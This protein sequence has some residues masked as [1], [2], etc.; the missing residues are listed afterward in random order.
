MSPRRPRIRSSSSTPL[1]RPSRRKSEIGKV[2]RV[3]P[4]STLR[5]SRSRLR[6]P[7]SRAVSARARTASDGRLTGRMPFRKQLDSKMAPKPVAT[8]A[9]NP[10]AFTAH[11]AVSREL[12]HPKLA[13]ASRISAPWNTGSLSG[14]SA[15]GAPV[16]SKRRGSKAYF[17]IASRPCS[18]RP[19]GV[20]MSVSTSSSSSGTALEV[21]RVNAVIAV[22]P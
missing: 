20:M 17:T 10:R 15:R 19:M 2:R 18:T 7:P 12:P 9:R 14:Q 5:A 8:T 13:P 22:S 6:S 11:A 21:S 4:S 1:R 3:R 16:S